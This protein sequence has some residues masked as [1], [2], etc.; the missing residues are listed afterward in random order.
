MPT[1]YYEEWHCE[2]GTVA[3]SHRIPTQ[4]APDDVMELHKRMSQAPKLLL[5]RLS[6]LANIDVRLKPNMDS[7]SSFHFEDDYG[8][9][10]VLV[11]QIDD[12]I[13]F[14]LHLPKQLQSRPDLPPAYLGVPEDFFIFYDGFLFAAFCKIK[15]GIYYEHTGYVV[16][17]YLQ[18]IV[19]N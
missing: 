14:K 15:P 7:T 4:E 18:N 1:Q 3:M 9:E 10:L 11:Y 12:P 17:R 13:G 19:L 5:E 2:V 6:S 16:R 8:K